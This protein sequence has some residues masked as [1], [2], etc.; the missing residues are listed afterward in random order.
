MPS[1]TVSSPRGQ[2]GR[3]S[4]LGAW[5]GPVIALVL[6]ATVVPSAAFSDRGWTGFYTGL[7][8]G[9]GWSDETLRLSGD[10]LTE[11]VTALGVLPDSLADHP[12]GVIGGAQAGYNHQIGW[13]VIGP[14]ADIQ[15]SSIGRRESASPVVPPF[16]RITTRAEQDLEFLGSVRGRAGVAL[17]STLLLYGTGGLAYGGVHLAAAL[18]N[19]GCIGLCA[20]ASRWGLEAGWAAG[21]GIEY[22]VREHWSVRAEYLHYDLGQ[23]SVVVRDPRFPALKQTFRTD[24]E[25]HVLR[26]GVNYGF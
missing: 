8:V 18:S 24:I 16:F 17:G 6:S 15:A 22:R 20:S 10:P 7:N 14:E 3:R 13:L 12:S 11:A 25:G 4:S 26:L 9:Y 5:C 23:A 21:G 1:G 2:D 19:P